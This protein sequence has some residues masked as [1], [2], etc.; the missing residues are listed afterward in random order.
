MAATTIECFLQSRVARVAEGLQNLLCCISHNDACP[1][2]LVYRNFDHLLSARLA[3]MPSESMAFELPICSRSYHDTGGA[4]GSASLLMREIDRLNSHNLS[5]GFWSPDLGRLYHPGKVLHEVPLCAR[6]D[7]R[8][9]VGSEG[10]YNGDTPLHIQHEEPSKGNRD[11]T[12][13]ISN[14]NKSTI[15]QTFHGYRTMQILDFRRC[16]RIRRLVMTTW[17]YHSAIEG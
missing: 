3:A 13:S 10:W 2:E 16:H 5:Q 8:P 15:K 9:Q 12:H 4:R 17:R 11:R 1:L 6:V 7:T 14:N